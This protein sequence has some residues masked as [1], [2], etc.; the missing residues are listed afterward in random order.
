MLKS[1][2]NKISRCSPLIVWLGRPNII[3]MLIKK[4]LQKNIAASKGSKSFSATRLQKKMT[5]FQILGMLQKHFLQIFKFKGCSKNVTSHCCHVWYL[6]GVKDLIPSAAWKIAFFDYSVI[7]LT[8]LSYNT[9]NLECS[10]DW[11]KMKHSETVSTFRWHF[12][13]R[14]TPVI[15]LFL[16]YLA[17]LAFWVRYCFI[18]H[19]L[20]LDWQI[21]VWASIKQF[22]WKTLGL[23][24]IK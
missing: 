8:H 14:G 10:D 20:Y 6:N 2:N 13:G 15:T 12:W 4:F 21:Y 11:A 7:G 19:I 9:P 22:L 1:Y 3:R 16:M 17:A 18:F 5:V 24:L 23:K